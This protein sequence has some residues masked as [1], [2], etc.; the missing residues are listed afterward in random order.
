MTGIYPAT[1]ELV[2][3]FYAERPDGRPKVTTRSVVAVKDGKPVGIGGFIVERDAGRVVLF[4]D[5]TD[6]LRSDKRL[7]VRGYRAVLDMAKAYG[8]RI[9]SYAEPTIDGSEKLLSHMGGRNLGNRV[10]EFGGA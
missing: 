10:Y 2:A 1:E 6:E 4:G 3:R 9:H 5:L 8:L 7:L